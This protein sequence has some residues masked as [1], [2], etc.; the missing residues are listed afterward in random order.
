M[1]GKLKGGIA[2]LLSCA[3]S[4]LPAFAAFEDLGV[5]ARIPAMGNAF[6]AVA[7]DV[8]SLYYNPAG[9][10]TL[11]RS[12][13]T[14]SY[15][16]LF[17]GLSDGSNLGSSFLAV[18]RPFREGER[19]TLGLGWQLFNLDSLYR[20]QSIYLS[21]GRFLR[22]D[23]WQ[24]KLYGG[25]TAK[26]LRR[27]LGS[28]SAADDAFGLGGDPLARSGLSDPVLKVG[29][30]S[31]FDFDFGLLYRTA[32]RYS[33]G[34][35]VLHLT[36]PNVA[37]D[38]GDADK[39]PRAIKFGFGVKSL[40]MNLAAEAVMKE[41]PAGTSDKVLTAAA[42]RWFP[43]LTH[44]QFGARGAL[45]FGSREFKQISLG[46]SYRI[47]KI[48]FDYGFLLPMGTVSST[49]GTHRFSLTFHFGAPTVEEEY[50]DL[51]L[52]QMKKVA[53]IGLPKYH[54]EGEGVARSKRKEVQGK[55][56]AAQRRVEEGRFLAAAQE[57]REVLR[58]A[59]SDAELLGRFQRLGLVTRQIPELLD[60]ERDKA[61]R[62]LYE[63]IIDFLSQRD[64]EAVRK[65]SYALSVAPDNQQTE[66]FL[67]SLEKETGIQGERVQKGSALNLVEQKLLEALIAFKEERYDR[68]VLLCQEVLE[69][70][71]ENMVA[72][73]RMGSALYVMKSYAKA[74]EVWQKAYG[75]AQD[76]RTRKN[77]KEFM[78]AL[79]RLLKG[80][81]AQPQELRRKASPAPP[82]RDRAPKVDPREIERLYQ[83][84]V[85]LYANG[86]LE[87]ARGIFEELLRLDPEN[88]AAQRALERIRTE[89]G[90]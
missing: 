53:Q 22:E 38:A 40:W 74:L 76:E 35:A 81:P 23:R 75:L 50:G 73:Q 63:G 5:G 36:E 46:G 44:G 85:T 10:G 31:F 4:S 51:L 30:K 11:Q 86:E 83:S 33:F 37:F 69:M 71:P 13:F 54:Y 14:S 9:L 84:G 1:K 78:D 48:Q 47:N 12:Q 82:G 21:Y 32:R 57:L 66:I 28:V 88:T 16:R 2:F 56:D 27:S 58:W 49:L 87:E 25:L 15:S 6:T 65:V 70:E 59:P 90:R 42:E 89:L 39:L 41:G 77:L 45:S 8:H 52:E 79:Q 29:S 17:M 61:R 34:L 24:G 67:T 68:V 3:L 19:G 72:L 43:T 62:L 7:D 64:R 60:F 26:S 80:E 20:E 18:A 55:L